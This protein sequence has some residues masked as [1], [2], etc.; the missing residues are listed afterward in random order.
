MLDLTKYSE[1]EL[2]ALRKA[3]VKEQRKREEKTFPYKVGDCFCKY[4]YNAVF[5]LKVINI[6]DNWFACEEIGIEDGIIDIYTWDYCYEDFEYCTSI[7]P[8]FYTK[9]LNIIKEKQET[10][11]KI[12]AKFDNNIAKI[13]IE[14]KNYVDCKRQ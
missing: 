3:I 9:V 11:D 7:N 5:L 8:D 13:L 10:V 14:L 4:D 2:E 1:Q 12:I 6:G